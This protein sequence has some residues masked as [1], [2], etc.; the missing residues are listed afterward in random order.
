VNVAAVEKMLKEIRNVRKVPGEGVWRWF[1]DEYI[2]VIIWYD[3]PDTRGFEIR[4]AVAN[5]SRALS[6]DRD[7]GFSHVRFDGGE[8]RGERNGARFH[9]PEARPTNT[10]SWTNFTR[11]CLISAASCSFRPSFWNS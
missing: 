4:Y 8:D 11:E 1:A 7:R 5:E 6:W 9:C 2:D 10:V 3:G